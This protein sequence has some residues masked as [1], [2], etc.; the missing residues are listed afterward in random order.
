M[1]GTYHFSGK[2]LI[3]GKLV[4]SIDGKWLDSINPAD[5]TKLGRVPLGSARDMDMAVEAAVQAF[6]AW[7][8]LS[9]A[10]RAEYVHALADAIL[11]RRKSLRISS[12]WTPAIPSD[13]CEMMSPRPFQG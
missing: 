4:E 11:V 12:L 5:E 2:M 13:P 6:P 9:M 10:K 8:G 1:H 7:A 3:G